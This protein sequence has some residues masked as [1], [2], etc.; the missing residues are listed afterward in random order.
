M[1]RGADRGGVRARPA[2]TSARR[3]ARAAGVR[4]VRTP[5][6]VRPRDACTRPTSGDE[7]LEEAF[8]ERLAARRSD[9]LVRRTTLVGPHRDDL[10]ARGPR[11]R[12]PE[13]REPRGGVGGRAVP[14]ARAREPR[15]RTRSA[16]GPSSCSTTRSRRSTPPGRRRVAERL[17]SARAGLRQRG[18]RGATSPDAV[19]V[20]CSTCRA[21]VG[22]RAIVRIDTG[23]RADA[24]QQGVAGPQGRADAPRRRRS[25][26]IVDGL[27]RERVVRARRCRSVTSRRNG[28][29]SSAHA[30]PPSRRR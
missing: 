1:G 30:S 13:L 22:G 12:C 4:G 19:G 6:R 24:A 10:V 14:S 27:L 9:E 23:E 15:S 8:A 18:R 16:S 5:G 26:T 3:G 20:W 7:P 28:P 11:P 29:P 25:A 21:G 17:A 2:P